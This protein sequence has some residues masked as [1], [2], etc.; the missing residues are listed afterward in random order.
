LEQF[1]CQ[2]VGEGARQV[3]GGGP[4]PV[5]NNEAGR[6]LWCGGWTLDSVMDHINVEHA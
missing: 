1:L 4:P 3:R 5:N 6:H 2:S